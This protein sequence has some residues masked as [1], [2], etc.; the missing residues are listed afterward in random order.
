VILDSDKKE[1][2]SFFNELTKDIPD[3]I[4]ENKK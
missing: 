4:E 3:L 1:I 2:D